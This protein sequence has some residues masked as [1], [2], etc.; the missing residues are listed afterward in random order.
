[1]STIAAV[2]GDLVGSVAAYLVAGFSV[3]D[4]VSRAELV[5]ATPAEVEAAASQLSMS[6]LLD[7]ARQLRTRLEARHWLMGARAEMAQLGAG[8]ILTERT[9]INRP[10]FLRDFYA[11]NRPILLRGVAAHWPAIEKWGRAYFTSV[12]GELPVEVM[13]GRGGAAVPEWNTASRLK[14]ITPMSAFVEKVYTAGPSND[15]YMVSRNHF[16]ARSETRC[17]LSDILPLQ[18][19]ATLPAPENIRMWFGPQGTVT[20]LHYDDKNNVIVQV[21]G[22]KTV[23]LYSPDDSEFMCQK[24][25]WYAAMDP[26]DHL[27]DVPTKRPAPRCHEFQLSP[28]DAL[29]IPV[30]WWHALTSLDVSVTLAFVE[31]GVNN[32]Y[33]FK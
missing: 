4:I 8:A 7:I 25:H 13:A 1:M 33:P 14:A 15:Y 3:S 11:E 24:N 21:L 26:R 2:S 29:F 10:E 30:G 6:P 16:F 18:I 5:S 32:E 19:F 31:F 23:C 17:L 28:G 27:V 12:L 22:R 20:P 9:G